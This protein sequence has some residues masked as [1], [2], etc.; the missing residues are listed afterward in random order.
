M[1]GTPVL[2]SECLVLSS[3]KRKFDSF[4]TFKVKVVYMISSMSSCL[5]FAFLF[6]E[7][8]SFRV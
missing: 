5:S 6:I 1:F 7:S 3:S 2:S 4:L 8:V